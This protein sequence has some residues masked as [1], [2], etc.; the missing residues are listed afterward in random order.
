MP[1]VYLVNSGDLALEGQAL[2][3]DDAVRQAFKATPPDVRVSFAVRARIKDVRG[4]SQYAWSGWFRRQDI[5][6]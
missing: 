1:A 6:E 5:I 4:S 3:H 2:S